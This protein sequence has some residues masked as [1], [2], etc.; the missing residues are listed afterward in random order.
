MERLRGVKTAI[1]SSSVNLSPSDRGALPDRRPPQADRWRAAIWPAA[2]RLEKHES[3]ESRAATGWRQAH[4]RLP[5]P[6]SRWTKHR[7]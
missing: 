3:V 5:S 7:F 1:A 4:A 2:E 6:Y